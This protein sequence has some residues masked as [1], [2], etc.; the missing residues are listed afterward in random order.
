M[1]AISSI[2]KRKIN[3]FVLYFCL[4][5]AQENGREGLIFIKS[6][7]KRRLFERKWQND[8]DAFELLGC[9]NDSEEHNNRSRG[10]ANWRPAPV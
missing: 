9:S 7:S 1:L 3:I 5:Y 6:H 10:G 2:S 8:S 4:I